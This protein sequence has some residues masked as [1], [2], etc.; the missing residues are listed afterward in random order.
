MTWTQQ[1]V[2]TNHEWSAI[3]SSSDGTKLAAV[4]LNGGVYTGA[5]RVCPTLAILQNITNSA[6]VI[7]PT[8]SDMMIGEN[9][10]LQ[11]ANVLNNWKNF[12]SVF[13]A[14]NTN[15]TPTNFW[16]VANTNQMFFRLQMIQ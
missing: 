7:I 6:L 16:N 11:I 9:Y 3:A 1:I 13:T 2:P 15:W 10:Q 5:I 4:A 12:G 8:A 14:T